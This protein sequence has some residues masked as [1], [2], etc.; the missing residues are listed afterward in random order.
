MNI[1]YYCLFDGSMDSHELLGYALKDYCIQNKLQGLKTPLD[2]SRDSE[3]GK[4]YLKQY[5]QIHFSIS[6]SGMWWTC[7][8]ADVEVGLDLQEI[9]ERERN[10]KKLAQ[11]FYHEREV[12]WLE[13]KNKREF[14]RLWA[15]KESY[16]KYTGV[17]LTHGLKYFC[18]ISQDGQT[19]GV[20]GVFQ[21]EQKFVDKNYYFVL[22]SKEKCDITMKALHE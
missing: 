5:P 7:V 20:D 11:R 13:K 21:K 3:V 22:T 18:A 17:G 19:L 8:I 4:P 9:P 16:V 15:Y 12:A 10:T 6:H 1:L 2:I 14:Y